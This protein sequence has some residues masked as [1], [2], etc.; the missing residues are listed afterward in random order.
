YI[1]DAVNKNFKYWLRQCLL[2]RSFN[3]NE[4]VEG[5][6]FDFTCSRKDNKVNFAISYQE[7]LI[8]GYLIKK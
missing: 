5:S 8:N 7:N 4:L 2:S 1:P 3:I 6:Y